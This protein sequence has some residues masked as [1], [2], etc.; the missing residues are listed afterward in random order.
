MVVREIAPSIYSVGALDFDRR[1]F[2]SLIPLPQGT[3][4]NSYLVKGTKKTALIDTV[5]P[6]TEIDLVTN[7]VKAKV[8]TIDYLVV[9][10]AEQDHSGSL[11]M[12]AELF[13]QA[14]VVTNEK[15]VDMVTHLLDI[16]SERCVVIKDRETLDLGGKTLEFLIT[17]WVHWP[18]TMLTYAREDRV[19]FSCDLFGSHMAESTLS[20]NDWKVVYQSA[21]RY[22][23]EIMMPFASSIREHMQ[24]IDTL[25]IAMIAPSHGPV[26]RDP[27]LIL[28]AYRDWTGGQVKNEVVIP[29]VSMHGSTE[30]MVDYLTGALIERG[31]RVLPFNLVVTDIGELAMALVDAA[32]VVIGTPTVI[33]GPHP[34]AVYATYLVNL[35]RPK[36]RFV[37]VIGSYGWGGRTIEILKGMLTRMEPELLDPVY[38]KGA[39]GVKDLKQ[40]DLLADAIASKHREIGVLT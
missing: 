37:S 36:T 15:C 8:D 27:R 9:N 4:Y 38:I 7:L 32:T 39:P 22:Y 25:E 23:A 31:I 18:E 24:K 29:Y 33:F 16:G 17:P 21:K 2:D 3:S 34:Q 11:P 5:D 14:K 12:I 28:D 30:K 19:L 13:P 1:L 40:L 35:L 26:Y 10:H 6:T 20:V